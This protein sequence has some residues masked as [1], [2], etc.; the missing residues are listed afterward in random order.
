MALK[1]PDATWRNRAQQ[2]RPA[3]CARAFPVGDNREGPGGRPSRWVPLPAGPAVADDPAVEWLEPHEVAGVGGRHLLA[4]ADEDGDVGDGAVVE[5][6]VAWL[7]LARRDTH[8]R[9]VLGG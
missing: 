3:R 6:Q 4:T 9:A 5:D 2:G 1:P 8:G 7:E